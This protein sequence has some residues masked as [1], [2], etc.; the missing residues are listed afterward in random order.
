MSEETI[1]WIFRDVN[2]RI[3]DLT[4]GWGWG[5]TQGFLC[6]CA[7]SNC[8]EGIQLTRAEYESIRSSPTHFVLLPGHEQP[9]DPVAEHHER[10]VIVENAGELPRAEETDRQSGS[11]CPQ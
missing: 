5:E 4:A 9:G 8:A 6:E 10:F 7:D 2:E 1:S 3:A 11:G